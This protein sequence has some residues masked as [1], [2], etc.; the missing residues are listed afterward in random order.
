MI[1]LLWV[2]PDLAFAKLMAQRRVA[3]ELQSKMQKQ[4]EERSHMKLFIGGYQNDSEKCANFPE[5]VI[6]LDVK[7]KTWG[8]GVKHI[9]WGMVL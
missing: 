9:F 5:L 8:G 6:R 3:A 1:V 7:N 2:V 4:V